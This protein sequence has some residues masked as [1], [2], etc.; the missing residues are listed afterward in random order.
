MFTYIETESDE[1]TDAWVTDMDVVKIKIQHNQ[2]PHTNT[3]T[4]TACLC[5]NCDLSDL[6]SD[7]R[8]TK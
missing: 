5:I 7:W 2:Q 8:V 4:R 1:T 3:C 6:A